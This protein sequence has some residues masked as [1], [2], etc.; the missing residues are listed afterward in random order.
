MSLAES[1][2]ERLL[3]I[4]K[5]TSETFNVVLTRFAFERENRFPDEMVSW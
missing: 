4:S 3:N 2:R 5:K 1:V